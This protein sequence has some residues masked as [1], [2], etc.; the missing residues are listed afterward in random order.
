MRRIQTLVSLRGQKVLK[1]RS[2]NIAHASCKIH[3]VIYGN[4]D[5]ILW[6]YLI[7]FTIHNYNDYRLV[8]EMHKNDNVRFKSL[9]GKSLKKN[10]VASALTSV[11]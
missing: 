10:T 11:M 6:D 5:Y 8:T 2:K 1:K 9:A 7:H 3:D 4:E